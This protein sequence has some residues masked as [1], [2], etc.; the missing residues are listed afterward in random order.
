MTQLYDHQLTEWLQNS[1]EYIARLRPADERTAWILFLL[2]QI[3]PF[4]TQEEYGSFLDEL[5]VAVEEQS[6]QLKTARV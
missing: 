1:G 4:L 3:K 5:K 6:I 2:D